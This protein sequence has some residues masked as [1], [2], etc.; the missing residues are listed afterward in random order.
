MCVFHFETALKTR[1]K[2]EKSFCFRLI[3]ILCVFCFLFF[4]GIYGFSTCLDSFLGVFVQIWVE[5][6]WDKKAQT[7]FFQPPQ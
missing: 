2:L 6:I 1:S 5:I 7:L 3:L 4:K